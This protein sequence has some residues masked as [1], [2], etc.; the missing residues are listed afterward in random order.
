V[1][2]IESGCGEGSR[3][4]EDGALLATATGQREPCHALVRLRE[5]IAP[6]LAAEHEGVSLDVDAL[7]S[8]IRA[9][10]TGFDVVLVEGAGGLLSP[11]SW[12]RDVT[13]IAR[14]LEARVLLVS[15]DRL[16]VLHHVR[17]SVKVLLDGWLLPAG[18]VLSAPAEPDASTGT[19]AMALARVLESYGEVAGRIASVPRADS[20]RAEAAIVDVVGWLSG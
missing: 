4:G 9:M 10:G 3:E 7:S 1:K 6:A 11:L 8:R 17:A 15:S 19:N 2:P 14:T 12:T 5:P 18:I 16:G 20:A 13:H